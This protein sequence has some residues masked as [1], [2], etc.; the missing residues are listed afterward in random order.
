MSW[1]C[2]WWEKRPLLLIRCV[3]DLS[4]VKENCY[5]TAKRLRNTLSKITVIGVNYDYCNK[6]ERWCSALNPIRNSLVFAAQEQGQK[7]SLDRKVLGGD[8]SGR[9]FL[10]KLTQWDYC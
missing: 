1:W 6:E 5:D 8:T 4:C 9:E 7:V 2:S 3:C 10:A